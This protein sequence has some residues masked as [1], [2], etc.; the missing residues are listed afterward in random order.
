MECPFCQP[1]INEVVFAQTKNF[2]AVYNIAPVFP[3][4][5]LIIPNEHVNTLMDMPDEQLGEMI[6]F[7]R[8]VA[9]LL[10]KIFGGEGF[11]LSLQDHE[12]AG[13]TV[14]HLHFHVVPRIRND[15]PEPGG[16]Y[17]KIKN[18][19][20]EI[21]DSQ[22]RPKLNRNEMNTIVEKLRAEAVKLNLY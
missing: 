8:D 9:R 5:S 16:W 17:P 12:V 15:M 22:F 2:L 7:A 13:Q 11:N 18:N 3:G 4:H 19:F 21:L 20:G 6:L 10:M 14:A 1:E